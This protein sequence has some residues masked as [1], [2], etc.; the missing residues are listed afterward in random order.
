MCVHTHA[1]LVLPASDVS[2]SSSL[3]RVF[4][5]SP[6]GFSLSALSQNAFVLEDGKTGSGAVWER[7]GLANRNVEGSYPAQHA[8]ACMPFDHYCS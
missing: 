5:R 4:V 8:N 2:L 3:Y 6:C 7:F 1:E